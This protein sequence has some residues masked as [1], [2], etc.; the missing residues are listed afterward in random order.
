M[1]K[2]QFLV[3]ENPGAYQAF[4]EATAEQFERVDRKTL[5]MLE[6]IISAFEDMNKQKTGFSSTNRPDE[7]VTRKYKYGDIT[8]F[9]ETK[10]TTLKTDYK[11]VVEEFQGFLKF[12]ANDYI[13]GRLRKGVLTI[14]GEAYAALEDVLAKMQELKDTALEGKEGISQSVRAE[15]PEHVLGEGIEKVVFKLGKDYSEPAPENAADYA[16]AVALKK[17]IMSEFYSEFRRQLEERTGYSDDNRPSQTMQEFVRAGNYLFPVQVTP[18]DNVKYG[19]VIEALIKPF[20]KK[21][22]SSTG[23]LIKLREGE[24]DNT[25]IRYSPKTRDG[26]LYVRLETLIERVDEIRASFTTP[27]CSYKIER[28]I[29]LD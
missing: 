25:L 22:T 15:A 6:K 12:I 3:L 21:I 5:P 11:T 28:S 18:K 20:N 2:P 29:H 4:D 27:S 8:V 23:E 9:V 24:T 10:P 13:E 1:D 19:R 17:T 16:R 7:A 26:A 14:E